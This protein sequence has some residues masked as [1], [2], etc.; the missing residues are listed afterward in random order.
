MDAHSGFVAVTEARLTEAHE[1]DLA[2]EGEEGVHFDH[3][4]LDPEI[5]KVFCLS[6]ASSKEAVMRVHERAGHPGPVGRRPFSGPGRRSGALTR[7]PVGLRRTQA[8]ILERCRQTTPTVDGR[9]R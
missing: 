2:V 8:Q 6:T 1:A 5:G 7:R 4:W 3:V 9:T